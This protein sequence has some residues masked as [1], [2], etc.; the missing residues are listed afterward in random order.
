MKKN[1]L[2]VIMMGVLVLTGCTKK[3][4]VDTEKKLLSEEYASIFR[5]EIKNNKDILDIAETISKSKS[6]EFEIEVAEL[7]KEDYLMGFDTDISGYKRVVQVA[8]I[9]STIPFVLYIFEVEDANNF[10][11][12]LLEHANKR[13]NICTEAD[14]IVVEAYNDN[15]VF[16]VMTPS[17]DNSNNEE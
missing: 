14:E 16:M 17:G 5:E 15:Y 7:D 3:T 8:P 6:I 2:L 9:I 12:N 1:I 13:W 11:E 10:A 4:N